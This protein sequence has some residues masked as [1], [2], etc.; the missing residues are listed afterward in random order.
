[1]ENR[2]TLP[3][4][5]DQHEDAARFIRLRVDNRPAVRGN[6]DM[7]IHGTLNVRTFLIWPVANS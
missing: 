6:R 5:L 2:G 3:E 4:I 1:M 7:V